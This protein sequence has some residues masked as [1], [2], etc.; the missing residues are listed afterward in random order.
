MGR[1]T[2]PP[3]RRLGTPQRRGPPRSLRP[4]RPSSARGAVLLLGFIVIAMGAVPGSAVAGAEMD[5]VLDLVDLL[6]EAGAHLTQARLALSS[7]LA[8]QPACGADSQPFRDQ[9]QDAKVGVDGVRQRVDQLEVPPKYVDVQGMAVES[10]ANISTA[11]DL[12]NLGLEQ[13]DATI[14]ESAGVHLDSARLQIVGIYDRIQAMPP[15]SESNL[16]TILLP[17]VA[18]L[19][20][21]VAVNLI[22]TT[23]VVR[24]E[25][26]V[27]K[28]EASECPRCGAQMTD[29]ATYPLKTIQAWM[30]THASAYHPR[31]AGPS[32]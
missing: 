2:C 14:I 16:G 9:I 12:L 8:D 3:I 23:R 26:R 30:A 22:Y 20:I 7:C 4:G 25:T 10:L 29:F 5:Y 18:G 11:L 31:G 17:V 21:V 32:R 15:T 13:F 1:R 6:D 24:R 28:R 27:R 19:V